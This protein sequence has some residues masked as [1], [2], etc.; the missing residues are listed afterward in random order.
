MAVAAALAWYCIYGAAGDLG[1]LVTLPA[2]AGLLLLGAGLLNVWAPLNAAGVA[3]LAAAYLVLLYV[4]GS[5]VDGAAPAVAAG[6]LLVAELAWFS[7]EQAAAAAGHPRLLARRLALIGG[8]ALGAAGFG[9]LLLLVA[10]APLPGGVAY[11]AAGAAAALAAIGLLG[12][13]VGSRRPR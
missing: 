8:L 12:R 1:A 13:L 3:C 10:V 7:L 9:Y 6:L 5:E 4:R 2:L 11:T